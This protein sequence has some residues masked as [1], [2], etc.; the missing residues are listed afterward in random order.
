[1]AL[2]YQES[3]EQTIT[4]GEQLH[5]IVNGTAT[6][7][8]TVEDGSK[9]PTVRKALIDNFYFKSPLDWQSGQQEVVFN[10]LR[11]FTDGTLWY[12]P[13]ATASNPIIMDATP[14]GDNNWIFYTVSSGVIPLSGVVVLQ[15]IIP[16]H[17]TERVVAGFYAGSIIGG[18]RF[19]FDSTKP[20]SAHNGGTII[21]P[22]VTWDGTIAGLPVLLN[23]T[24]E[25]DP[26]GYGCW[27]RPH[28][29]EVYV[30]WFGAVGDAS[31][32]PSNVPDG[33]VPGTDDTLPVGKC[34]DYIQTIAFQPNLFVGF[35]GGYNLCF[36]PNKCYKIV[37][38]NPLGSTRPRNSESNPSGQMNRQSWRINGNGCLLVWEV[39][40][41]DDCCI[42]SH[43]AFTTQYYSNFSVIVAKAVGKMGIFYSNTANPGKNA[44]QRHKFDR[45]EVYHAMPNSPTHGLK[46]MFRYLGTNLG[47]RLITEQCAFSQ[48]H[49]FFYSENNEAVQQGFKSTTFS[50]YLDDAIF[51]HLRTHGSGF[52]FSAGTGFLIKGNRQTWLRTEYLPGSETGSNGGHTYMDVKGCRFEFSGGKVQTVANC[53]FGLLEINGMTMAP[54]GLPDVNSPTFIARKTAVIRVENSH[55]YGRAIVGQEPTNVVIKRA[56]AIKFS[57]CQFSNDIAK[58]LFVEDAAGSLIPWRDAIIGAYQVPAVVID[59][60]DTRTAIWQGMPAD[61]NSYVFDHVYPC[62]LEYNTIPLSKKLVI[63]RYRPSSKFFYLDNRNYVVLPP[64]ITITSIK[65]SHGLL[66]TAISDTIRIKVGSAFIDYTIPNNTAK[67]NLEVLPAGQVVVVSDWATTERTIASEIRLAGAPIG[68]PSIIAFIEIEWRP[69]YG[70]NEMTITET[71]GVR[72]TRIA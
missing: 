9:I 50:C 43:E 64:F 22:T 26:T 39:S 46:Y 72:L 42:E 48:A 25:T 10:Q 13:N 24:T 14:V 66:Y 54:G 18:G 56:Y 47:D 20:K 44:T 60:S 67:R 53:D 57:N 59:G 4:A 16:A 65:L 36:E 33:N 1:M 30:S 41:E 31:R 17:G 23:A 52:S 70:L 11:K 32:P 55:V 27:V 35:W 12:A 34:R 71:G 6:T 7:E 15:G 28:G 51:F 21:S 63:G 69:A 62:N 29:Y 61:T 58:S 2:T 49:T 45:V 37:G 3:V 8:V 40:S 19:V 68:S 5:Q 38:H